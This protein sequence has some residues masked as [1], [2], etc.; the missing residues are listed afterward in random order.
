MT[1]QRRP[2]HSLTVACVLAVCLLAACRETPKP[3]SPAQVPTPTPALPTPATPTEAP[4]APT[5]TTLEAWTRPWPEVVATV[6]GVPVQKAALLADLTT[7]TTLGVLPADANEITRLRTAATALDG[8]IDALIVAHAV[9]PADQTAVTEEFARLRKFEQDHAGGEGAWLASLQRRGLTVDARERTLRVRAGLNVLVQKTQKFVITEAELR[10]RFAHRQQE[11][12]PD[13]PEKSQT[14]AQARPALE[15]YVR[16]F[17][18]WEAGHTLL[19]RLRS[20]AQVVRVPPFD[21]PPGG[22]PLAGDRTTAV[23]EEDDD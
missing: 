18:L 5:T 9:L 13:S 20:T 2:L 4:V 15:S 16:G 7:L 22:L 14:F 1:E 21:H 6:D 17:R 19:Q 10:E 8:R 23:F 12:R 3:N 11:L